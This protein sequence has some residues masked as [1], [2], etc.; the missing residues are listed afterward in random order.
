L[1]EVLDLQ[2]RRIQ[3]TPDLMPADIIGTNM[4]SEDERG[5]RHFEFQKGPLFGQMILADEV[6]RA[7]PKTQ[8]ALLEAM[9][10][11]S[12]TVG[13]TTYKLEPPF[14]VMATQNPLEMDGTYPLPEAQLDRFFFKILVGYPSRGE[15]AAVLDRTVDPYRADRQVVMN[16][17]EIEGWKKLVLEVVMAP[18]VKDYG[19]RVVLA[20]HPGGPFAVAST[21]R[22]VRYG[23]SPRGAQALMLAAKIRA[24]LDSRYNVSF[25]DIRASAHPVLRHR[26]LLNFEAEAEGIRT[27]AIIDEVLS[28][29]PELEMQV[30]P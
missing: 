4:V 20:T 26:L 16:G 10:E 14:F 23:S 18:H 17:I 7:T 6:N 15:L 29:T 5:G 2:F 28:K 21:S 27:D 19:V 12:V 11:R 30:A 1:S 25:D 13:D 3:F 9:Q 24:L 22:Y 8:S